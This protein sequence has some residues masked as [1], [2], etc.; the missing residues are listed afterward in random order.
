MNKSLAALAALAL[1]LTLAACSPAADTAPVAAPEPA[2]SVAP[3]PAPEPEPAPAPAPAPATSPESLVQQTAVSMDPAFADPA[4][5]AAAK[6]TAL[7]WCGV[8]DEMGRDEAINAA[9]LLGL[10]N[11][12]TPEQT[13]IIAGIGAA[14]YCPEHS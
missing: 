9:V 7:S 4:V 1:A 10:Q 2:A 12:I 14:L 6:D 13:G 5:W 8:A 3:E 11:G